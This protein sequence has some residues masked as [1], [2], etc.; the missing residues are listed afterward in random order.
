VEPQIRVPHI[1]EADVGFAGCK[2]GILNL[3]SPK[4]CHSE[5]SEESP[6]LLLHLQLFRGTPNSRKLTLVPTFPDIPA[7]VLT[8]SDRC[9][10]NMQQDLSGPAISQLLR[11]SGIT[12][13]ATEILPDEAPLISQALRRHASTS[14]LVLTTG[15][16]GLSPRDVTPEATLAVLDR[17]IDGLAERMRYEGSRRTPFAYLSRAICG[18]LGNSLILNLPGS[19]Q[20]ATS[21]LSAVLDLLPHALD[22]LAGD[23]APHPP[24][25]IEKQGKIDT[26]PCENPPRS[27]LS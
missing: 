13:I 16:T 8:I 25:G 1:C 2:N 23:P 10:N 24:S 17:R 21:S 6:Y 12:R 19:P 26:E 15:G 14:R 18:T 9:F 5:R 27:S 20:G 22:L 4:S 3:P 11:S 7:T